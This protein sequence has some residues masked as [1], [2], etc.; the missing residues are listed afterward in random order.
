MTEQGNWAIL[1]QLVLAAD[2]ALGEAARI[3]EQLRL[4]PGFADPMLAGIGLADAA[5]PVGPVQFLEVVGP[6]DDSSYINRWLKKV[7]GRGGYCLS[8]QVPDAPAAKARARALGVRLAA[9][10]VLMG[11]PL[12][13]MHPGDVGILLELDGVTDPAVW[14]WDDVTPGPRADALIDGIVSVTVGAPD[15][16]ATAAQWG[17]IIGLDLAGPTALDFSGCAIDFVK[18][19]VGQLLGAELQ[20]APGVDAPAIDQLLGLDVSFRPSTAAS[21]EKVGR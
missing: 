11:H 3:A 10:E 21:R 16:V 17:H 13:Q 7:G 2:D 9:D 1:R 20:L 8:V 14:F 15:P 5:M 18:H 6:L 12:F 4:P 19:P